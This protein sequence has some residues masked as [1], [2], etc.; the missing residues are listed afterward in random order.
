[1]QSLFPLQRT[2]TT[3]DDAR[4]ESGRTWFGDNNGDTLVI[5]TAAVFVFG[6]LCVTHLLF[7]IFVAEGTVLTAYAYGGAGYFAA[8]ASALTLFA[9][10]LTRDPD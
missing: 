2:A 3:R 8:M 7:G 1:M 10:Y 9:A 5:A 4:A 6:F